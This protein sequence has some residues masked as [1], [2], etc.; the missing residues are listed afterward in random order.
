MPLFVLGVDLIVI[1]ISPKTIYFAVRNVNYI[2]LIFI[3]IHFFSHGRN[4]NSGAFLYLIQN[5]QFKA[6]KINL[7]F[8]KVIYLHITRNYY[9]G[10]VQ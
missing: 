10:K 9:F 8:Y 6:A 4:K 2:N 5:S 3:H 7:F 1:V